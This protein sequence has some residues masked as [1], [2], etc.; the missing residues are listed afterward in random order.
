MGKVIDLVGNRY[1]A[2]VVLSRAPKP[3]GTKSTS[4]FWLCQCDCGNTKVISGNVLKQGKTHSCGC[5]TSKLLAESHSEDLTGRRFG[6]LTVM[7][8]AERP[9]GLI[10]SGTY[11]LCRCD[12]GNEKI[13]MGKSLQQGKTKSCGCHFQEINDIT[14]QR[15]GKLTVI[16]QD[17]TCAKKG[18]GTYWICSCDCGQIKSVRKGNLVSG[19]VK[20]CGCLSSIG[21]M[22]IE[23]ILQEN[24]IN[25]SK[26]YTFPDL[27]GEK[28]GLLRFD[29]AIIEN[30][31][32][33]L[34]IEFQGEQHYNYSG[35]FFDSPQDSDIKKREYCKKHNI[36]L[37]LIPYWR[38]GKITLKELIGGDEE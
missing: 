36:P 26:Q 5:L 28:G 31:Q 1:G 2:L 15:F 12:C 37:I 16:A 19:N 30:N 8:R 3:E 13:I 18:D 38:R 11:W 34:L 27:H 7:S 6:S 20:S 4:A 21:E 14:G 35:S 9:E 29:F 25:Y 33:K 17:K 10:S 22:E 32:L 23:K 24:N